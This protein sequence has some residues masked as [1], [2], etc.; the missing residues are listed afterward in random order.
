MTPP[1]SWRNFGR[2]T[3]WVS[4]A[5]GSAYCIASILGLTGYPDYD[6][7]VAGDAWHYWQGLAYSSE[8]YR[9]SPAFYWVTAPLRE[10][11]FEI[12]VVIWT[13]LHLAAIAWLGPWTILLAFDDVIRGNVTTFLALGVVLAVRGHP[14]T[15]A[16]AFLT[17]VTPGVGILYHVGR[18]D[19]RSVAMGLGVTGA[20]VTFG[21]L[22]DPEFWQEWFAQLRAGT[23]NYPTIDALLPLPMRL[24]IGAVLCL[25]AARWVWL[26][27]VGMLVAMP[28]LWPSSFA[29]LAAEPRLIRDDRQLTLTQLV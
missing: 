12:F 3:S 28:G 4:Y 13:G 14:W 17:K 9:Y 11:P 27:P 6:G 26:L 2:V 19:W 21:Y 23:Q 16:G 24:A 7:I 20:I 8:H 5:I 10:L 29:I 1:A 22:I 18:R 15:W 25:A